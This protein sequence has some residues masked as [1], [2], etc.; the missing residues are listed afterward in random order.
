MPVP[1]ALGSFTNGP[2]TSGFAASQAQFDSNMGASPSV[3]NAYMDF[4][5]SPSNWPGSAGYVASTFKVA[6]IPMIGLPMSSSALSTA[7]NLALLEAVAA[8]STNYVDPISG[9]TINWPAQI[10]GYVATF[11]AAGFDTQY[12][13]PCVEMN[14]TSTPGFAAW[15]SN[16]AAWIAAWQK[17]YA[18]LDAA[19]TANG[20]K[21]YV[22]WNPGIQGPSPAGLATQTLYPGNGFVDIIGADVYDSNNPSTLGSN[23]GDL[24]LNVLMEFA[25]T[26]D[27]PFCICETGAGTPGGTSADNPAFVTWLRQSIDAEV[28]KGMTCFFVSI[29]DNGLWAFT[30]AASA[31]KPNEAAAWAANF[32]INAPAAPAVTPPAPTFTVSPAGTQV[33]GTSGSITDT[34]GNVWTITS[35]AQ[36]AQNGTVIASSSGVVSL[37]WTGTALDQLNN[38]GAW[39]TQPLTG[40]AGVATTAPAGYVPPAPPAPPPPAFTVS[41]ATILKAGSGASIIDT[42]G[43][44]WTINAS[45]YLVWNTTVQS[46]AYKWTA[47]AWTGSALFVCSPSGTWTAVN[48]TTLGGTPVPASQMQSI[49]AA[50]F[51]SII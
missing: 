6:A 15:E 3:V 34:S 32:G 20:V 51:T 33:N 21:G 10:A 30:P 45:E 50:V 29:W 11:K 39:W 12:W 7:Q 13:R 46:T 42:L 36:I 17:Y 4:T 35:G 19:F 40:G 1:Y 25:R 26:N 23:A 47:L 9:A 24:S 44:A 18:L 14:M 5:Q 16:Q 2:D 38:L 37:F 43:N 8:G 41:P 49:P 22:I 27:K 31:G 28:E 48:L